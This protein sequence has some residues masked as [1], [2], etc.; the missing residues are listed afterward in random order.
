MNYPPVCVCGGGGVVGAHNHVAHVGIHPWSCTPTTMYT[1]NYVYP[2]VHM[3]SHMY[4]YNP[5]TTPTQYPT[6]SLSGPGTISHASALFIDRY[7]FSTAML[8]AVALHTYSP[9][10]NECK[11]GAMSIRGLIRHIYTERVCVHVQVHVVCVGL[12]EHRA[13]QK[14][15]HTH[16]TH[17]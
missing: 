8:T 2:Q 5:N 1:H 7:T 6:C 12:Q 17:T 11:G 3:P 16:E 4:P 15:K 13:Q 10:S 14:M 9:W